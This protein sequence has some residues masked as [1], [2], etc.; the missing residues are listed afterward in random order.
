MH[1]TFLASVKGKSIKTSFLAYNYENDGLSYNYCESIKKEITIQEANDYLFDYNTF[2]K[3]SEPIA[4][5]FSVTEGNLLPKTK[6][7]TIFKIPA[8]DSSVFF[9]KQNAIA[10]EKQRKKEEEQQR[11]LAV[12]DSI[13]NISIDRQNML[14]TPDK[15]AN[16]IGA[17]F[18]TKENLE[19]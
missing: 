16:W 17:A 9:E 19:K 15:L 13:N 14:L 5:L 6:E 18:F 10:L 4:I 2:L 1:V 3:K 7:W 8:Y 12:F 11:A